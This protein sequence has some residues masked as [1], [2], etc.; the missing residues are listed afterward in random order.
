MCLNFN[1]AFVVTLMLRKTLS[2]L[3]NTKLDYVIPFDQSVDLH[4]IAGYC[5][6]GYSL[7]H[8]I[9]HC[10]NGSKDSSRTHIIIHSDGVIGVQWES[11]HWGIP[12]NICPTFHSF[13]FIIEKALYCTK[14]F[15]RWWHFE[16][17][18][19]SH[20][21]T[22]LKMIFPPFCNS[23]FWCWLRH[24]IL[25]HHENA[26]EPTADKSKIT[27]IIILILWPERT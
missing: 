20:H 26:N 17:A 10:C 15:K 3:R 12:P 8:S 11:S 1:S 7:V 4:K 13:P 18:T 21:L 25:T 6:V 16:R 22:P 23:K 27:T 2:Y 14:W 9:A 19:T 5:I 24:F